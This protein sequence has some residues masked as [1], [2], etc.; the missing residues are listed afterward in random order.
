MGTRFWGAGSWGVGFGGIVVAWAAAMP[1]IAAADPGRTVQ[2]WTDE[3]GVRAC[4]DRVPPQYAKTQR[5]VVDQHGVVVK[6][7]PRERTPAEQLAYER[8]QEAK[9]Q[10]DAQVRQQAAYDGFLLQGYQNV[11]EIERTRDD[12]L[13]S[14]DS[15][16]ALTE[17]TAATT[18]ATL[19]ELRQRVDGLKSAGKPVPEDLAKSVRSYE[20]A[21]L[22]TAGALSRLKEERSQTAE[23][24]AR[25]I[26]RYRVLRGLPP[27]P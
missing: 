6:V 16:I 21:R 18:D 4:G 23:R 26:V 5:E 20:D 24:F 22:E 11:G 25:D 27:Q 7:L 2:C 14:I 10:A 8:E 1:T 19:G 12:R 9:K 3:H 13:S 17:K 15:R